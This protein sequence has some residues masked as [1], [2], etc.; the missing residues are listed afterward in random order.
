MQPGDHLAAL[1]G[2]AL[3]GASARHLSRREDTSGSLRLCASA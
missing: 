1:I 3:D 2:D